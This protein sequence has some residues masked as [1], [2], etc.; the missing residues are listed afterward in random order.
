M[1]FGMSKNSL[2]GDKSYGATAMIWGN[3]K[4]FALSGRYTKITFNDQFATTVSNT[5][6]TTAYAEG[7][8]FVFLGYSEVIAKPKFGVFGYNI[9][10]GGMYFTNGTAS[11]LAAL[12]TFYMRPIPV[13]KKL[14]LTPAVFL[15]A[16]PLLYGQKKLAVDKNFGILAGS[17]FD[18]SISKRFKFGFDYKLSFGTQP[19]TPILNFLMIGSKLQL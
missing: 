11:Y 19:G 8:I 4:Q 6:L 7:N 18:Y 12:T 14:I 2:A 13:N 17:T 1:N 10:M 16:T 5:S 3:L 15:N 9:N